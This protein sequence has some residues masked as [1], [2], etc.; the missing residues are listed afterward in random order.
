MSIYK[1]PK[2]MQKQLY[3]YVFPQVCLTTRPCG[4][5]AHQYIEETYSTTPILAWACR[6]LDLSLKDI[7]KSGN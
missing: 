1:V 4:N 2:Q 6:L 5:N 3:N 7:K